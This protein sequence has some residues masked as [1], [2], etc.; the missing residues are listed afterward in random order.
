MMLQAQPQQET[1]EE[2][3]EDGGDEE[4]SEEEKDE[5]HEDTNTKT[6]YIS[7]S[8]HHQRE[9]CAQ[10]VTQ[11]LGISLLGIWG[12]GCCVIT[13]LFVCITL[14][15]LSGLVTLTGTLSERL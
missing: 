3:D 2:D 8:D 1:E 9:M 12:G 15:V 11:G 5:T 10:S 4:E 14:C 7:S 13:L 6:R